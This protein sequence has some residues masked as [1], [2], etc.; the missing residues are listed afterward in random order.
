MKIHPIAQL[1]PPMSQAEFAALKADIKQHGL[2]EPILVWKGQIV[3]GK[4]RWRACTALRVQPKYRQWKSKESPER[5][6]VSMNV[7]RRHLPEAVRA[8]LAAR[9]AQ[10][11][12][13]GNQ[14][15]SQEASMSQAEAAIRLKVSRSSVQRA[16]VVYE[17]GAKALLK[18][19]MAGKIG[20]LDAAKVA[21][22]DK[23][24]Q[25]L[26]LKLATDVRRHMLSEKRDAAQKNASKL[27]NKRVPLP[28]RKFSVI[29]ADP[30][31]NYGSQTIPPSNIAPQSH[32]LTA[33]TTKI[34]ALPIKELALDNAVLFLWVPSSLIPDGLKVMEAWGFKYVTSAVWVKRRHVVSPG[35]FLQKHEPML[36][37]KR[38]KGLTKPAKQ[39]MSVI[40]DDE[41]KLAHSQKPAVVHDMI[42]AMY[43][44]H[45]K[46][47]LYARRAQPGWEAWGNELKKKK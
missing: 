36:I 20:L 23:L 41:G 35:P 7:M 24:Q 12:K 26:F 13:G 19:L 47:E 2:S 44:R 25:L 33:S 39:P 18:E 29:L 32:Y 28:L 40:Q 43:P 10:I 22:W 17:N 27:S 37:G 6:V 46:V 34:A 4:D 3:D 9:L 8:I 31:W 21:K 5:Y 14:H 15:A 16:K 45:P 42:D 38:G 30:P 11:P 1:F